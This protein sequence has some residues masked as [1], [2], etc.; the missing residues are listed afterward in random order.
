MKKRST[1]MQRVQDIAENEERGYSRALGKAQ[2]QL[3]EQQKR[4]EELRQYRSEYAARQPKGQ[5]GGISSV[6]WADYQN[7]LRR[8][9]D[10]VH[11]QAELVADG[12]RNRDA[13]R[14]RW[15]KKRQKTESLQRVV[16]RFRGD[17]LRA[18]ERT[19]Q[20]IQD[21]LPPQPNLFA[22]R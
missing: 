16:D 7:F 20:K 8:L 3:D 14:Q 10:A 6:Q 12:K 5:R 21:D 19:E 15:M 13:H 17:E 11:A 9:D 22:R 4:L 18:D 1:R 2:R